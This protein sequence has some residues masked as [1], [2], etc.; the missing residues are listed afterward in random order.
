ML[1]M[2]CDQG[3]VKGYE[4]NE[5]IKGE[6]QKPCGEGQQAKGKASCYGTMTSASGTASVISVGKRQGKGGLQYG[7][8]N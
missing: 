6:I 7:G 5:N 1:R 4:L 2:L 3:V 8:Q